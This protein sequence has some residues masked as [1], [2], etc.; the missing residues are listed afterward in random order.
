MVEC[1]VVKQAQE[2]EQKIVI[3]T[4]ERNRLKARLVAELK[5]PKRKLPH[6]KLIMTV[7]KDGVELKIYEFDKYP[8]VYKQ[9]AAIRE[10]LQTGKI[11]GKEVHPTKF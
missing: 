7:I 1:K 11:E 6:G 10:F 3:L 8:T 5:H 4:A 2:L 9:V